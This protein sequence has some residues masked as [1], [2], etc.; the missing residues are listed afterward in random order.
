VEIARGG[1]H[2]GFHG[3]EGRWHDEAALLLF[4]AA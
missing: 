1:G 4:R 2:V 3:R